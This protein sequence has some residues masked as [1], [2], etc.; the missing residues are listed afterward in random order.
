MLK[1]IR[2]SSILFMLFGV[3]SYIEAGKIRILSFGGKIGADFFPKNLSILL[4][5]LSL[6][7]LINDLLKK[8]ESEKKKVTTEEIGRITFFAIV[9]ILYVFLL[10]YFGFIV[11]TIF[12]VFFN[13]ILLRTGKVNIKILVLTSIYSVIVAI[14]MWYLFEKVFQMTLPSGI[15]W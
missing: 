4:I 5:I 6:C 3:L 14:G 12:L 7:W 9:F 13:H 1:R 11:T 2:I 15:F 10:K 8:S